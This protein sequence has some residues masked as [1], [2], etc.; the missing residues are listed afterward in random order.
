LGTVI[1]NLKHTDLWP[2]YVA[3]DSTKI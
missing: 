3:M 1:A 2:I